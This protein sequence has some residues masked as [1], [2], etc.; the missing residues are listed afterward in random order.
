MYF[1]FNLPVYRFAKIFVEKTNRRK[2]EKANDV[3]YLRTE[4]VCFMCYE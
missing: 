2:N 4:V 3:I 1:R